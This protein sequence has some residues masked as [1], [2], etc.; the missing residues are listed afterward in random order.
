MSNVENSEPTPMEEECGDDNNKS[1]P[2]YAGITG[3]GTY[4]ITFS[5]EA[6]KKDDYSVTYKEVAHMVYKRLDAPP[7]T[8]VKYDD[9]RFGKLTITLKNTAVLNSLVLSHGLE[10][11][12]GLRTLPVKQQVKET[13]VQVFW[14]P[15]SISN[16]KIDAVLSTFGEVIGCVTNKVCE[17]KE[18][19]DEITKMMKGVILTDRQ[20]T[21]VI[22][23]PIPSHILV[24]G[25]KVKVTYYGQSR[26]CSRCY[27]YWNLC[28][29]GGKASVCRAKA[30][31]EKKEKEGKGE[32]APKA[33]N[34]KQHWKKL[35]KKMDEKM[36][37]GPNV[38]LD[39]GAT[40][41]DVAPTCLRLTNMPPDITLPELLNVMKNNHCGDIEELDDKIMLDN[42]KPGTAVVKELDKIDFE[43]IV[44]W[45]DGVFLR[46]KR[47]K[48]TPIQERTPEKE[49]DRSSQEDGESPVM[50]M[51]SSGTSPSSSAPPPSG[52]PSETAPSSKVNSHGKNKDDIVN[53]DRT[54]PPNQ[55]AME[56]LANLFT[57]KDPKKTKEYERVTDSGR[58]INSSKNLRFSSGDELSPQNVRQTRYQSKKKK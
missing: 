40:G 26:T 11:R 25:V 31:A 39:D 27:K 51:S 14:A 35:T 45:I 53:I 58:K 44:E 6:D 52:P 57:G 10:I 33:P 8:L 12:G 30:E 5:L 38:N 22:R 15:F 23:Y 54:P 55:T 16:E 46:G 47:I 20:C 42:S 49:N 19:D 50:S 29:G 48:V 7:W 21:M 2:T 56:K 1:T 17:P 28:P 34:M 18:D 32:K 24:E 3:D 41:A 9:T 37:K 36:K 43:L 13:K 4:D